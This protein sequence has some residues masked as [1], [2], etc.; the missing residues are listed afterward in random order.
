MELQGYVEG[1]VDH[2]R[3]SFESA[4]RVRFV[5]SCGAAEVAVGQ[6]V[7]LGLVINEFVTNSLQHGFPEFLENQEENTEN[8]D[9]EDAEKEGVIR[10]S[11]RDLDDGRALLSV[12]DD[13]TG[14]HESFDI[15]TSGGLGLRIVRTLCQQLGGEIGLG[16][17]DT[18][19]E[20][21]VGFRPLPGA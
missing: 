4:E 17:T 11:V 8:E 21:T 10:I 20:F 9:G 3:Q 12:R 5:V 2:L 7:A 19:A 6:G 14:L 15:T 16:E 13:G 1:L 18:G